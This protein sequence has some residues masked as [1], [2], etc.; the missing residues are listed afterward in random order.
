MSQD[1]QQKQESVL[2]YSGGRDRVPGGWG[3]AWERDLEDLVQ[4]QLEQ[5]RKMPHI[6]DREATAPDN[7]N[8]FRFAQLRCLDYGRLVTAP[9]QTNKQLTLFH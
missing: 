4:S 2:S 7:N 1:L 3:A 9:K 5:P 8:H 6:S